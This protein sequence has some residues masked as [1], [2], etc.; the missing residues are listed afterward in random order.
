MIHSTPDGVLF[1]NTLC[2]GQNARFFHVVR[3][4]QT[5]IENKS[6]LIDT[7]LFDGFQTKI[8]LLSA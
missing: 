8:D 1:Y 4:L 3:N 2:I 5:Y 6:F 7:K